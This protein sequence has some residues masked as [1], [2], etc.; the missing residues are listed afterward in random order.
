MFAG[1]RNKLSNFSNQFKKK[2]SE[3]PETIPIEKTISHK[4]RLKAKIGIGKKVKA[5]VTG[6][7]LISEND[8][9]TLLEELELSLLEADV[10]QETALEIVSQIKQKLVGKKI[11]RT[12]LD[13]VLKKE[14]QEALLNILN[15][16]GI[17]LLEKSQAKKPLVLL[18]LGPNGAGKTTTIAKLTR[19][20]QK[21]GKQCVWAASDTFRAAS[22]E[23][24]EK[25]AQ[26]LNVRI[27][28]HK[29]GADPAAVA[30]DAIQSAQAHKLDVV[31]IDSAGR[32]ETNKNLMEELKKIVRVAKPDL[33]VFVAESYSGQ[34]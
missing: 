14:I 20:F 15:L 33:K 13:A 11:E 28:K 16:P 17:D 10:E 29:Y 32:Q 24:L 1:L 7:I 4:E 3:K 5:M 34:A 23:Q 26:Q 21:N 31:L 27:I 18:L 2:V 25:H 12:R 19:F 8:L 9:G 6:T 30:F 22:I